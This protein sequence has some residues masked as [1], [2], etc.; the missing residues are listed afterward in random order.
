MRAK[1]GRADLP[2]TIIFTL[3]ILA[4]T[5]PTGGPARAQEGVAGTAP[6]ISGVKKEEPKASEPD[7]QTATVRVQTTLVTA[8]V[9]VM[10]SRGQP[11]Y[12]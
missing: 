1:A 3:C 11:L 2:R 12:D 7:A 6:V 4:F 5:A 9:A 8:S 10:D